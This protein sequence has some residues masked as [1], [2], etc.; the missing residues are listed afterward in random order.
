MLGSGMGWPILGGLKRERERERERQRETTLCSLPNCPASLSGLDPSPLASR[1]SVELD[2]SI[3]CVHALGSL[4]L[5]WSEAWEVEDSVM[6]LLLVVLCFWGLWGWLGS[7]TVVG[8]EMELLLV[9][10]GFRGVTIWRRL[11]RTAWFG[12]L[13]LSI[14]GGEK[15]TILPSF[16]HSTNTW[17]PAQ[18]QVLIK[19]LGSHQAV[20]QRFCPPWARLLSQDRNK[21]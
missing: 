1:P 21:L 10:S 16:L 9:L 20:K 11:G 7:W 2:F 3:L 4:G 6:E 14:R 13:F 15:T 5:P 8:D 17:A 18:C 19:E 12:F